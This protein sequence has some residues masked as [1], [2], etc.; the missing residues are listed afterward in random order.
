MDNTNTGLVEILAIV[1][2]ISTAWGI[3]L[4]L[5]PPDDKNGKNVPILLGIGI[6]L[7]LAAVALGVMSL[8]A[9]GIEVSIL[10]ALSAAIYYLSKKRETVVGEIDSIYFPTVGG[11]FVHRL[12]IRRRDGWLDKV[13]IRAQRLRENLQEGMRVSIVVPRFHLSAHPAAYSVTKTGN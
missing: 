5:S 11:T 1:S 8:V 10:A 13:D 4:L 9:L 12:S 6:F 3:Y 7:P 2:L